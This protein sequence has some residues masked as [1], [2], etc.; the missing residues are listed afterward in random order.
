MNKAW[1]ALEGKKTYLVAAATIA[2]AV[3]VYGWQMNDWK[4]AMDLI[5]GALGMSAMRHGIAQG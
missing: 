2:Y 4:T 3:V 5:L 1:S